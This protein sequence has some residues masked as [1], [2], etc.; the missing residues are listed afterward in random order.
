M[1]IQ[2]HY[3][4]LDQLRQMASDPPVLPAQLLA[5]RGFAVVLIDIPTME[6]DRSIAD[7]PDEVRDSSSGWMLWSRNSRARASS[8][9]T[10]SA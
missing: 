6:N 10:A 1:V 4:L 2:P 8:T 7:T 5:A 3:S 9:R